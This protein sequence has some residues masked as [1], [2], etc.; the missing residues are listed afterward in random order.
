[1]ELGGW[2]GG[3]GR[4]GTKVLLS[5]ERVKK[6]RKG[7]KRAGGCFEGGAREGGRGGQ[8]RQV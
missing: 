8:G 3:L 7:P 2:A 6:G 4:R 1:M 5:L